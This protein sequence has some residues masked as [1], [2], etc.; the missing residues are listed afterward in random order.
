MEIAPAFFYM[1]SGLFKNPLPLVSVHRDL[2]YIALDRPLVKT[3]A[4]CEKTGIGDKDEDRGV[5]SGHPDHFEKGLLHIHKMLQRTHAG[6][7]I[8]LP[9]SEGQAFG[10]SRQQD[11]F[12]QRDS[13]D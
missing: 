7:H 6:D 10:A 12:M 2:A 1:K 5:I 9:L 8:E 4:A 13:S 11:A 3:E